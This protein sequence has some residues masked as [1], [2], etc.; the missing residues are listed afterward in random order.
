MINCQ[1]LHEFNRVAAGI[2]FSQVFN[3]RLGVNYIFLKSQSL[4]INLLRPIENKYHALNENGEEKSKRTQRP[5][6]KTHERLNYLM[7]IVQ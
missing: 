7:V 2:I 5:T 6:Y 4:H 3:M 1:C